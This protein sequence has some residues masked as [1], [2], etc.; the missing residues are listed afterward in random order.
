MQCLAL[1]AIG[2]GL[3]VAE[4]LTVPTPPAAAASAPAPTLKLKGSRVMAAPI[5][6]ASRAPGAPKP[7][8]VL[9]AERAEAQ[10]EQQAHAEGAVELRY[11]AL[12]LRTDKLDYRFVDD[13][14]QA[15]GQVQVSQGGNVFA[16]PAL[17]LYLERFEGEFLNPSYFLGATG[18]SGKAARIRFEGEH[19]IAVES[20]NYSSCPVVEGQEPAWQ[21]TARSMR[22]DTDANEGH[23]EGAK[24]RFQGVT[25]L[26]A[27]ALSF[28]L[29]SQRKSGLLPP[30][31]FFDNR[32][33]FEYGQPYYWNIAPQ[34]D[35]TFTPF[36]MTR[37][38]FGLDSEFRYLEPGHRGRINLD[39]LPHDRV[40]GSKRWS[41][42]LRNDGDLGADWRY[43]VSTE[44]V[45]DESYWKDLTRRVESRTYRLLPTDLQLQRQQETAWGQV[46]TYARVQ[47]WQVLQTVDT[48]TRY[49][50]PF[51][52]SPQI[53]LRAATA[54][55]EAVLDSFRPW[56]RKPRLEG[57]LELE[58]NRFDLPGG[59]LTSQA[60]STGSRAHLLAH[61]AAPMGGEAWWLIPRVA[62][63]VAAYSMDQA[64]P[65]GRL[66][67]NR[68]IPSFSL[69]HGWVLERDTELFGQR[70]R[71]SLEPRVLYVNTPYRAQADLPNFDSA[72]KDF[73]FDSIYADNP[74]T[75]VDRVAD[76]HAVS[77]GATSRW[78]NAE[79]GEE[80]FRFGAV[81]RFL[82]RDQRITPEGAPVN[83]RFSDILLAGSAHL[84]PRWW[85]DAAV[86]FNPDTQRSVRSVLRGRY[87]PGPYRTLSLAYR[88]ARG[89][90]EQIE[91]AWQWPLWGAPAAPRD[92]SSTSGSCQGAWYSAGRVQYSLRDR[93]LTDSVI[94]A[95]YDAG[96][97]L[98]RVGVERLSTGRAEARTQFMIQLELVGLSQLGSNALKVLKDNVPGYR[99]LSLDRSPS[100]DSLP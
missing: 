99:R 71:Q 22:I 16:G 28:P 31:L 63:N 10:L 75:G 55:D 73:N 45:S 26:A 82:F 100:T 6:P 32:S 44:R 66:R 88:L 17:Q 33:G 84:D 76:L 68:S 97:W 41:Y 74:F 2:Q 80:V 58:F 20:G 96:C 83:Q 90:S 51:Q 48:S 4:S 42:K 70:L 39:L 62:V 94:G 60:G 8:L 21:I 78:V 23:A 43:S 27:P 98:L 65:D 36:V 52:R 49:L 77:V 54:A 64:G 37:R 50:S 35:A 5:K 24:L 86:E 14:A 92:R 72:P 40:T 9:S 59:A 57:G 11:G 38:G 15:Q 89:Q 30:N 79:R 47:R 53:G 12:L 95:E 91:A 87:A 67:M 56:G 18:G 85:A 3:A 1:W 29:G 93:R 46:E 25:I 34:R 7:A 81:Q 61:V 13:L 19:R 69:D